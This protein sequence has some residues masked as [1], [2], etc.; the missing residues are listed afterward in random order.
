[1]ATVFADPS[2]L[3]PRERDDGLVIPAAAT[4]GEVA[5]ELAPLLAASEADL[6]AKL[7]RDTRF[8]YLARQVPWE[9]GEAIS[10]LELPGIGVLTEPQRVYPGGPLAGQ[11]L[12]FTGIDGNG[13]GGLEVQYES[14][15]AGEP[16]T[17]ALERAPG[18][19]DIA[20]GS[21]ELR[22]PR[23][24]TDLVLTLDREI[25]HVAERAAAQVMQSSDALGASVLVLDVDTGDVLAMASTPGFDPNDVQASDG[26]QRR[27]RPATD[28]F[29]PGSVQKAVTV[30]A[31]LEEGVVTPDSTFMV[32]DHLPVGGHMFN[33]AHEHPTEEM[34]VGQIIEQSS[35]IGTIMIGQLLGPERLASYLE[36]FGYGTPMGV[37]FPG[38]SGGAYLPVDQWSGTSLPTISMGHGV[39]L[40]LLQAASIY[41]TIANDGV[42]VQPRLV[43]GM[44]GDD[45]RLEPVAPAATHRIIDADTAETIRELLIRVVTGEHGTAERAAIPGYTV[46]GKTGTA[47]KPLEDARGYSGEYMASFVGFAPVED[48]Q[49]VVAV[50]VDE[51]TPIYGGVVAAPVFAEVMRF[52]LG[53]Q[54]V[55]PSD[56]AAAATAGAAQA[57]PP[58]DPT[59]VPAAPAAS[60]AASPAPAAS[61]T[62][63]GAPTVAPPTG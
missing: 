32:P 20:S 49:L 30:A 42:A 53:H 54:R 37:G 38:E 5:R 47:K 59:V 44:V 29:E 16:G 60:P 45:G 4:P 36:A 56:P 25:Q 26:E 11:V 17:L 24:G 48:P 10:E 8:V 35:N 19:L 34:T 23:P 7:Q 2:V 51:P 31:A 63:Q 62:P 9:L 6:T 1:A 12:G 18:G 46:A 41:A 21:R 52:A 58:P 15:L 55:S 61:A 39:A 40:T 33:D 50:L 57:P 22:P 43:R 28:M 27:N 13:L 3:R 14:M